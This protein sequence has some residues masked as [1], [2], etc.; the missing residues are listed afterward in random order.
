MKSNIGLKFFEEL[1]DRNLKLVYP[2]IAVLLVVS[3]YLREQSYVIIFS[4]SIFA[5]LLTR[6]ILARYFEYKNSQSVN[7]L[8]LIFTGLVGATGILWGGIFST[9]LDSYGFFSIETLIVLGIIFTLQTGG[10]TTFSTS[11]KIAISHLVALSAI[12]IYKLF[13]LEGDNYFVL[14]AL[15]LV[16]LLYQI[17]HA[18]IANKLIQKNFQ[19]E[20]IALS[21]KETI[22]QF[23]DAIPG[24]VTVLDENKNYILVNNYSDGFF[25]ENLSD[26][27]LGSLF[28]DSGI[29]SLINEFYLSDEI[30]KVQEV[31]SMDLGVE[32]WYMVNLKKITHPKTGVIVAI[33]PITELV[34]AKNDLKI[35]EA[36]SKYA[37]KLASLGELS[38]GIAHEVNNPLTIIEGSAS[39]MK[40]MMKDEELDRPALEKSVQKILDTTQRIARIIKS[41]KT[42]S[43]EA[44]DEP[45]QNIKFKSI[46]EPSLEISK[47]KLVQHDITLTVENLDSDVELFGNE[48]QLS[49]VLMNLIS[50]AIDAVKDS[51]KKKLI[52]VTYDPSYDW[53]DIL[54]ADNGHGVAPDLREK[55]MEPFFTTKE[56]NQGTGLGLSISRSVIDSHEGSL[57]LIEGPM[58]TFR[59]RLP[60]MTPWKGARKNLE[61]ETGVV[62]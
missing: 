51:E 56:A 25:K 14:S 24:L 43:G 52:T 41:L 39:L 19:S 17:Y 23:I 4:L 15:I 16:N 12:P 28:P 27:K 50:N 58:T 13:V 21:Q 40:I 2:H 49:Q 61:E 7:Q 1:K 59:I 18:V 44:T 42:L 35:Q 20:L 32:N 47:N 36:R 55:I 26:K 10:V 34:Q 57:Q 60:R 29:T 62:L 54:V 38:A 53:L 6:I 37:S 22:Q 8:E 30:S 33:L 31:R 11:K 9:T 46:V 45:F 5:I 48:V 3:L